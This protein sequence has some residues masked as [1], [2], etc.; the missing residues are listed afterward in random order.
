MFDFK[1]NVGLFVLKMIASKNNPCYLRTWNRVLEYSFLKITC[2]CWYS[3]QL[4]QKITSV[5]EGIFQI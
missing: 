5:H 2:S 4:S 1:D 3:K